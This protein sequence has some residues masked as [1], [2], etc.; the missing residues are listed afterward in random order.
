MYKITKENC[1]LQCLVG[2]ANLCFFN[3]LT[4]ELNEIRYDQKIVPFFSQHLCKLKKIIFVVLLYLY[5]EIV[6]RA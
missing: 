6:L 3:P 5:C 4:Y 2:A 1:L